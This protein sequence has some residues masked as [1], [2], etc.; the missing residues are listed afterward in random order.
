M[1]LYLEQDENVD[2]SRID[3]DASLDEYF[4]AIRQRDAE[5]V[6]FF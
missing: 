2:Y 6:Y 4:S 3:G 5:D 1:V